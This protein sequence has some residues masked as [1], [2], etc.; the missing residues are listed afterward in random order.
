MAKVKRRL[1]LNPSEGIPCT[2]IK[3]KLILNLPM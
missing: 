1:S 2:D 3:T